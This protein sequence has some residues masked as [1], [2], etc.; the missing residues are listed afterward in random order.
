[1]VFTPR[2][3]ANR[4]RLFESP[5]VG[6]I[7]CSLNRKPIVRPNQMN[8]DAQSDWCSEPQALQDYFDRLASESARTEYVRGAEMTRE[9]ITL[10]GIDSVSQAQFNEFF[11]RLEDINGAGSGYFDLW[12]RVR[13]W[14]YQ[15]GFSV[16]DDHPWRLDLDVIC[17]VG[18][19]SFESQLTINRKYHIVACDEAKQMVRVQNDEGKLRW[20]PI[21]NFDSLKSRC[22]N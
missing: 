4:Y 10:L 21:K 13:H 1:M 2:S 16:P 18:N 14:G 22:G 5:F 3:P 11:F 7:A 12:M 9:W 8:N 17:C 6:R 19:S 15:L 20:Y